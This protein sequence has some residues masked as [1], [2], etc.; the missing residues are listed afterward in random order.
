MQLSEFY[1]VYLQFYPTTKSIR[2]HVIAPPH[3]APPQKKKN[4]RWFNVKF[5]LVKNIT[6][7]LNV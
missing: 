4:E 3:P 1:T 5:G 2:K 7:S 6:R